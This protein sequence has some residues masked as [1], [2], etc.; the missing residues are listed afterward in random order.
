M[1]RFRPKQ[2][3]TTEQLVVVD[4]PDEDSDDEEE[5]YTLNATRRQ[6]QADKHATRRTT[7][8]LSV[9]DTNMFPEEESE[10]HLQQV[11]SKQDTEIPTPSFRL[12]RD[13]DTDED[14]FRRPWKCPRKYIEYTATVPEEMIAKV[15]EYDLD[16]EDEKFL[17]NLNFPQHVLSKD[18]YEFM[19]DRFESEC[20]QDEELPPFEEIERVFG[21]ASPQMLEMVYNHWISRRKISGGPLVARLRPPADPHRKHKPW[22][23]NDAASYKK[24]WQL[25]QEMEHARTLIEMIRKREK[26]KRDLLVT[27]AEIIQSLLPNFE[28]DCDVSSP[29]IETI[30]VKKMD[31]ILLL[32][33]YECSRNSIHERLKGR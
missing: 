21:N 10:K 24:M 3:K 25:R 26:L 1:A 27:R 16:E 18:Q 30:S 8:S 14:E 17:S 33:E 20:I 22:R 12:V 23:R 31:D 6:S 32:D 28:T 15:A 11:I 5:C 29:E 2:L 19:I 7:R 4:S 13:Y 9:S